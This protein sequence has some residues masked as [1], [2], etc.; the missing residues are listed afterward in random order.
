MVLTTQRLILRPWEDRDRIPMA[1]IYASPHVRR[2]LANPLTAEEAL[3]EV[4]LAAELARTNGFHFQPAELRSSGRLIGMIGLAV[5]SEPVQAAIHSQPCVE[6]G[7][8]L[9]KE[10]WGKGLA[11]EGALAWL[12]YAW[13][14]DLPE[15][16]GFAAKENAPSQRVMQK[17]GMI[18]DPTSDYEH[19]MC[20][21]GHWLRPQI[22]YRIRNPKYVRPACIQPDQK[23]GPPT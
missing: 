3:V 11:S 1:S 7:W 22:V 5:L 4:D 14:I 16:A 12:E 19:P 2:Y 18:Y 8:F 21:E 17:I 20:G 10:H 15:V 6:I 9:A 23:P 13:S